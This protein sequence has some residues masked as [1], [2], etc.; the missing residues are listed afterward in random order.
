MTRYMFV[1]RDNAWGKPIAV[2][3]DRE[4]AVAAG[5]ARGLV[6]GRSAWTGTFTIDRVPVRASIRAKAHTRR[7]VERVHGER[8]RE[9][10][11]P[12]VAEAR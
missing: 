4:T 3:E 2:A 7:V 5:T 12:I 10:M 9:L 1:T 11:Q 6:E 8:L